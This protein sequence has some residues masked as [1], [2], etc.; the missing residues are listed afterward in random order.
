NNAVVASSSSTV[1]STQDGYEPATDSNSP[2]IALRGPRSMELVQNSKFDRCADTSPF[3][4]LCDKGAVAKDPRDGN[5][6]RRV[7]VCGQP[8]YPGHGL[9][10]VPVLQACGVSTRHPGSFNLTYT[11]RNSAGASASTWRQITVRPVC[12]PGERLCSNR[13]SVKT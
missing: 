11:V 10:R 6:D 7:T 12:Q 1:S 2:R 4:S 8:L 9:T 3:K 13:V 5:L